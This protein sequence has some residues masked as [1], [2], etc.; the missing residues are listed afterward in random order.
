MCFMY[1]GRWEPGWFCDCQSGIQDSC[2]NGWLGWPVV[3]GVHIGGPY[4]SWGD[5]WLSRGSAEEG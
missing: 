3:L 5:G 1:V 4:C 2:V